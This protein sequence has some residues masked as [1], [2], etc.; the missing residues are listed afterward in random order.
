VNGFLK[1]FMVNISLLTS[2]DGI[3]YSSLAAQLVRQRIGGREKRVRVISLV[4]PYM[5]FKLETK[6][7]RKEKKKKFPTPTFCR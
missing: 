2:S 3:S 1:P 4:I 5:Y 7:K 6:G